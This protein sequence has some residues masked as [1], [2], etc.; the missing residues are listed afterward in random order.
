[1]LTVIRIM[2]IKFYFLSQM[3]SMK[4]IKFYFLSQMLTMK[5]MKFYFYFLDAGCLSSVEQM[6]GTRVSSGGGGFSNSFL[7]RR[8]Q[9]GQKKKR[10]EGV[11]KMG[12]YIAV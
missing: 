4:T 5:T 2:T 9:P 1:M 10:T 12:M 11:L 8:I 7:L 6:V 3:L